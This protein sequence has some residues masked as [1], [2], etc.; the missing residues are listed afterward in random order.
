MRTSDL[1]FSAFYI[2]ALLIAASQLSKLSDMNT[3]MVSAKLYPWL[4]VGGGLAMGVLETLR[5]FALKEP[6]G[7]PSFSVIWHRAFARRRMILL[8]AFVVYLAA[9]T[10]VGFLVATTIFCFGTILLL[11]PKPRMTTVIVSAL[12]TAGTL[13]LIYVLLVVYLEAFLP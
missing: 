3:A 8:A 13:G 11:T 2:V 4:V 9:I 12:T 10:F 7:A 5:T 6:E 1:I